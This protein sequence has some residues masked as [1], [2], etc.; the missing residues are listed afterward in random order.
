MEE[1]IR[2]NKYIAET[3]YCSRR[4]D[5]KLI[6]QNRITIN[7]KIP[8]MGTKVGTDDEVRIDGKLISEKKVRPIYL[9][10]H[11]PVGIECTTNQ[12]VKGNIIDF[13][14]YPERIFPIGRLDK[15]SEGLILMTNDG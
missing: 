9:A 4:E 1:L 14:N 11:K 2:I 5:D 12:S 15:D 3:G 13:I 8:E 7:G 6:E 10:F